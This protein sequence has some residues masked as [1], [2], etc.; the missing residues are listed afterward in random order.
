MISADITAVFY[1]DKIK[2]DNNTGLPS[3]NL[4]KLEGDVDWGN[5]VNLIKHEGFYMF[6]G[7]YENNEATN[8]LLIFKVSEVCDKH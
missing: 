4:S 2:S 5:T 6:G 3:F 7:R 8:D 1:Q